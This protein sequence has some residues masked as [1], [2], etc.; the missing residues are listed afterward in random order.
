MVEINNQRGVFDSAGVVGE[1][2]TTSENQKLAVMMS[3]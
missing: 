1:L 2:I 3:L